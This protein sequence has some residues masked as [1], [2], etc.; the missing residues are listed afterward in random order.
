MENVVTVKQVVEETIKLLNGINVP[1]EKIREIGIPIMQAVENLNMCIS[2]W[3]SD[4]AEQQKEEHVPEITDIEVV[5][6]EDG[7][8]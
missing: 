7:N 3:E 8:P 2:A 1:A 5:N 4:Q 6:P